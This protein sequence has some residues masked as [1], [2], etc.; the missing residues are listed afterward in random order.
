MP[1]PFSFV[2]DYSEG[3]HERILEALLRTNREQATPYGEDDYSDLA[4][5]AIRA[6]CGREDADVHFLFGGTQT[7]L[8]LISAALRPHQGKHP[9]R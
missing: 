2:N 4:R 7:N 6:A 8:T 9:D 5:E 1:E 3:A